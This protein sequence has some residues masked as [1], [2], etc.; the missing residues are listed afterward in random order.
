MA[1]ELAGQAIAGEGGDGAALRRLVAKLPGPQQDWPAVMPHR[2]AALGLDAASARQVFALLGDLSAAGR[3]ALGLHLLFGVPRHELDRWL[4]TPTPAEQ[5]THFVMEVGHA[6]G[7]IPPVADEPACQAISSKLADV[8][9]VERGRAVRLH[10]LG[11]EHC[12][13]R[14]EGVR[15]TLH[16]LRE[17]IDVLFPA[18]QPLPRLQETPPVARIGRGTKVLRLGGTSAAALLAALLI[19]WRPAPT[20]APRVQERVTAAGLIDRALHRLDP[21]TASGVLHEQYQIGTGPGALLSERWID[22]GNPQRMRLTL[23]RVSDG[24]KL[25]DLTT[26]GRTRLQY[27][28]TGDDQSST[29]T[30]IDNPRVADLMPLLRQLPAT[31]AVGSFPPSNM[32][33]DLTLLE[34]ARHLQP[35]LLGTTTELGRPAYL[36][37]YTEPDEGQHI[38]LTI[39]AQTSGLLRATSAA[40]QAH[41]SVEVLW[42]ARTLEMLPAPPEHI[43]DLR[44]AEPDASLPDPRHLLFRP[45]S[46]MTVAEL[47]RQ[48]FTFPVPAGLPEG[49]SLAYLRGADFFGALQVY[50]G[51]W[52]SAVL[53]TPLSEFPPRLERPFEKRLGTTLWRQVRNDAVRGVT[54]IE[55]APQDEP[56][57]RSQLYVW[58]ALSSDADR[59]AEAL[60][61]LANIQWLS[62]DQIAKLDG[63]FVAPPGK[64]AAG[65]CATPCGQTAARAGSG[66]AAASS[67]AHAGTFVAWRSVRAAGGAAASLRATA[68]GRP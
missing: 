55:F 2:P 17:A 7:L 50:E 62:S 68:S 33:F 48:Y 49:T 38:V 34:N 9:D 11:C 5:A 22:N 8:D 28:A 53:V 13:T 39:D 31:G 46:N 16:L 44:E 52:S 23:K 59:D 36:L 20:V 54:Q 26:D 37:T 67:A 30:S 25:L 12:R 14:A 1:D 4:G 56:F 58:N 3:L 21:G 61:I 47:G 51:T 64:G 41:G 45:F 40:G 32:P 15:R 43:F 27:T 60:R 66:T 63:R 35:T 18:R 42:Q 57:R 24:L 65:L 29:T 6:I 19:I 10:L